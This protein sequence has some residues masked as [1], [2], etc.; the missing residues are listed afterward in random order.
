MAGCASRIVEPSTTVL[1]GLEAGP[2]FILRADQEGPVTLDGVTL[3]HGAGDSTAGVS[4]T[5][6]GN[7]TL[8]NSLIR[9]N[10]GWPS[11]MV[12]SVELVSGATLTVA[13]STL[14]AN[15]YAF[16]SNVVMS[17]DTVIVADNTISGNTSRFVGG[18]AVGGNAVTV[19]NTRIIANEATHPSPP[20]IGGLL[21]SGGLVTITNMLIAKNTGAEIGGLI[22][23]ANSTILTNNTI[24][25]NIGAGMRVELHGNSDTAKIYNN[26]IWNNSGPSGG[27]LFLENDGNGDGKPSGMDL[28]HNDFDQSQ[29]VIALPFPIDPSNLNHID[30]FV[31][32]QHERSRHAHMPLNVAVPPIAEVQVALQQAVVNVTGL[33]GADIKTRM[34]T[35]TVATTDN[36]NWELRY[37][38]LFDASTSSARSRSTWRAPRSRPTASASGCPTGPCSASPT[39]RSTAS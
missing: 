16:T 38:E 23:S 12:S 28:S 19:T 24:T 37:D 1:D 25:E 5:A 20:G 2:V 10:A 22:V 21:V 32:E 11:D 3:Q 13:N 29:S 30:P 39:S 35:G 26:I 17:G 9:D 6:Q 18:L 14:T 7:L 33:S 36:R 8:T 34:R 31:N 27:D 4:L 15:G